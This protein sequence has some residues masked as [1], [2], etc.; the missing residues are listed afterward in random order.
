MKEYD[1]GLEKEKSA[2]EDFVNKYYSR[3]SWF[4]STALFRFNILCFNRFFTYHRNIKA[5][6]ILVC[7]ME[8]QTVKQNVGITN[9][10]EDKAYFIS[11]SRINLKST[12][13]K[14]LIK[15]FLHWCY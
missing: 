12:N 8:R 4:Y 9:I 1:Q 14:K 6:L 7:I 13:V 3:S 2:F 15:F 11:D 5:K 10:E